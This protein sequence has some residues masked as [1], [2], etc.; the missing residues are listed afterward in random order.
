MD[1]MNNKLKKVFAVVFVA[2][3]GLTW[4]GSGL[5]ANAQ[6]MTS[7]PVTTSSAPTLVATNDFERELLRLIQELRN[8]LNAQKI[9]KQIDAQDSNV[10][11]DNFGNNT[12]I[13]GE[14]EGSE[15]QKEIDDEVDLESPDSN[16][17]DSEYDGI[18]SE[19]DSF[20]S[21]SDNG[22]LQRDS[23]GE[24]S[25]NG[26]EDGSGDGAQGGGDN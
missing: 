25:R 24:G 16:A 9:A 7:N 11:G 5:L 4:R 15:I 17:G 20:S 23:G 1:M 6:T 18:K 26:S 3:F 8:D 12:I 21:S 22:R 13:D 19:D 10:A 14:K 2:V